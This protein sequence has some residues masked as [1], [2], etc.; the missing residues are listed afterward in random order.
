MA[1]W[2]RMG[3]AMLKICVMLIAM[4]LG[5]AAHAAGP[6]DT[7]RWIYQSL[8]QGGGA[9]AGLT[10]LRAPERSGQ[11]LTPRLI[12]FFQANDSHSDNL[13][14]ACLDFAPDISGQD[15]DADEMT[16]TLE[17]TT[18]GDAT[19]QTVTA[20]FSN[21]GQPTVVAYDFV[22]H[23]GLWKLDDIAGSGW[24]LSQVPCAPASATT[25]TRYCYKRGD[26]TLLLA[27]RDDGTGR[28]AL[29]SWQGGGHHCGF[30]GAV[31]AESGRWVYTGPSGCR[32]EIEVTQAGALRLHDAGQQCKP[33]LCGARAAIDGMEFPPETQIDCSQIPG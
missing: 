20:R 9:Q 27:P 11:F 8:A 14:N 4:V 13:V 32:V 1:L 16:R 15:F 24:R 3:A 6:E 33:Q 12:A 30:D 28:A 2:H 18:E 25:A 31:R 21:F 5:T 17:V 22:P 23:E 10:Y 19:R 7:V 26:S 29:D